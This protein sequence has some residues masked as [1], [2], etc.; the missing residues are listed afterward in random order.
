MQDNLLAAIIM[1]GVGSCLA[2]YF[3]A[4]GAFM[5]FQSRR[6]KKDRYQSGLAEHEWHHFRIQGSF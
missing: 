3:V 6:R 1:I 2:L 4:G 5:I